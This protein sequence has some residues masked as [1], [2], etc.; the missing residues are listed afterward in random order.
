M[1]LLESELRKSTTL[2]S[3]TSAN[4]W[5]GNGSNVAT[6]VALSGDAALSNTGVLGVNKTRLNVRNETGTT[7]ASTR[8]VYISGFNNLP[9]ITLADNTAELKHNSVGVTIAP[10]NTSSDGFIATSGQCDAE[11]NGWTVGTELY[12]TSTGALTST[13]PTSGSLIHIGIV[14]VQDNYPTGKILLYHYPEENYLAGG[15]GVDTIIRMGDSAGANKTSFRDYANNEVASVNSDGALVAVSLA[16]SGGTSSQFLKA[17]G[18]VD[19]STY[20]TSLSGALLA[21]GATT[22]ATSQAQVFTNGVKLS[23]LTA[24][25]VPYATTGGL[26]TDSP[27]RTDGTK[28]AVGVAVGAYLFDYVLASTSAFSA[29]MTAGNRLAYLG[30]TNN[31]AALFEFAGQYGDGTYGGVK[32]GAVI[33][34]AYTGDFV[35]ANRNNGTWQENFRIKGNGN[36]GIGVTTP[37]AT[38]SV[39]SGGTEATLDW[40]FSADAAGNYRNGISTIMTYATPAS[41]KMFFRVCDGYSTGHNTILTLVGNGNVGIGTTSPSVALDIVGA[42]KASTTITSGSLTSGRV[43]FAGASGLL[44]DSANLT[45]NGTQLYVSDGLGL[46]AAVNALYLINAAKTYTITSGL[47]QGMKFVPTLSPS[48]DGTASLYGI[49]IYPTAG[50]NQYDANIVCGQYIEPNINHTAGAVVDVVYGQVFSG[51]CGST[52]AGTVT[53]W[54]QNRIGDVAKHASSTETITNLYALYIDQQNKGGTNWQIYSVAGNSA[55]GGNTRFGGVTAPSYAVDATG[56]IN[57]SVGF[58]CGGTAPIAD[59]TYNM[60]KITPVTGTTGTITVKG[61]IITNIVQAT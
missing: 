27:F 47:A 50:Q 26:L 19:S 16:K 5:V 15:A 40:A 61:G 41:C 20:L 36:V 60:G 25:R 10:I 52:S 21:T 18:T 37:P 22:G 12:L 29:D 7:I 42:I 2:P 58:R 4:I 38:L 24:G 9:L 46:G 31:G 1:G 54:Y 59:G 55:F 48:A 44:T 30:N 45:F 11:T 13:A 53:N 14:T 8:A 32:I 56:S 39:I 35:V 23:N 3:L 43:T 49:N 28:V 17:D 6:A 34:A 57:A 51:Y 33:S